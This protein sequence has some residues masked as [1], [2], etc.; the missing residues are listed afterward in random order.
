MIKSFSPPSGAFANLKFKMYEEN[1]F[2]MRFAFHTW[3]TALN[4]EVFMVKTTDNDIL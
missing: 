3:N 4:Y 2:E 1:L